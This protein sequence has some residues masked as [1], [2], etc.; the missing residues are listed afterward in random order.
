MRNP[1]KRVLIVL[2]AAGVLIAALP[3]LASYGWF[4]VDTNTGSGGSLMLKT[5]PDIDAQAVDRIPY[6]TRIEVLAY[7]E[8]R[9][10][11]R[12][13]YRGHT[14]WVM[15]K[16]LTPNEPGMS[17]IEKKE[18]DDRIDDLNNEFTAMAKNILAEPYLVRVHPPKVSSRVNLRWAPSQY[19]LV[20]RSDLVYGDLLQVLAEGSSW[21]QVSDPK[22]GL[23]GFI[24]K[25]L[26]VRVE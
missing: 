20:M 23:T 14:G 17:K 24:I 22:T 11:A 15:A 9:A 19:A 13:K 12:T 7:T 6:G 4:Y 25:G 8:N 26:T 18:T 3:A 1:W 5:E 16:F 2:L 21:L 10:W